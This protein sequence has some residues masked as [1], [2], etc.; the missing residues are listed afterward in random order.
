MRWIDLSHTIADGMAQYPG[1]YPP[2]RLVRRLTFAEGGHLVTALDLGCHVGTHIDTPLH[3]LDGQPGLEALPLDRFAGSAL[4]LDAPAGEIGEDALR[5]VDLAGTDFVLLR[6]GWERHWG[7]P[8]YYDSWPTVSPALA[9][10]LAGARLK[11]VGLDTP[12]S[13]P[14]NGRVAHDLFAAAG[15]IN[16]ENLANLA[17][18]PRGPFEFLVLPLKLAGTEAS[19]VRAVARV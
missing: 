3:F 13:D 7:T 5:G 18:L 9:R 19:P 4:C 2:P 15:L 10:R 14:L 6:T 16:I 11:G 8:R 12:S 1:D 17:A